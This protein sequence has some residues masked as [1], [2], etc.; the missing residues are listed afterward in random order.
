M[1][2]LLKNN[3]AA[4]SKLY[5]NTLIRV[6]QITVCMSNNIHNN[7][8]TKSTNKKKISNLFKSETKL[9]RHI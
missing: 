5:I 3:Y 4:V 9:N 7:C 8:N 6:H 1:H 2:T